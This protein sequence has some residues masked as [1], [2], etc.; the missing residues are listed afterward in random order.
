MKVETGKMNKKNNT[1]RD[2]RLHSVFGC[3]LLLTILISPLAIL[4][5]SVVKPAA[6]IFPFDTLDLS[7][8]KI[9]VTNSTNVEKDQ[10]HDTL[11]EFGFSYVD[12]NND[13]EATAAECDVVIGYQSESVNW[14]VSNI[15]NWLLAGKGFIHISDWP[16]WFPDTYTSIPE[17]SNVTLTLVSRHIITDGLPSS[18]TATGFWYYGSVGA[19]YLAWCTNATL[20]N[21]ANVDGQDR[22]VT[23]QEVGPG[24][25]VFLGFN[26]FGNASSV[27]SK[28]LFARAILWSAN[29]QVPTLEEMLG[30]LQTRVDSL[31][32]Q[33]DDLG[34]DVSGLQ[35][36]LTNLQ[37]QLNT[38]ESSLTGDIS[39]LQTQVDALETTV[40]QMEIDLKA[41]LNTATMMGYAGIGIGIIGVVIA[42]VAI[43]LSRGKKPTA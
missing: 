7:Q 43:M 23:A 10:L 9:G 22:V 3:F 20:P 39:A 25:A 19:D 33:L 16:L 34:T 24:R 13:A 40:E 42:I 32:T 17:H 5:G 30:T 26:V 35:T 8:T 37:N 31:Q 21:M 12:V 27:Y 36:Q 6:A 29:V 41:Q 18:W 1:Q 14:P 28:E 38:M 11:A 4:T 2:T 15:S